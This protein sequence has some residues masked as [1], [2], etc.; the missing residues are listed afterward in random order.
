MVEELQR[1]LLVNGEGEYNTL[2][3]IFVCDNAE[4]M[5]KCQV[6]CQYISL[7]PFL[8]CH[9]ARVKLVALAACIAPLSLAYC[10]C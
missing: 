1:S 7:L 2:L 6:L 8:G 9:V 10:Q 4:M 5:T 3:V